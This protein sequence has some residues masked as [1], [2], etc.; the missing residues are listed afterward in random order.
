MGRDNPEKAV[1]SKV[2]SR[3][4][5]YTCKAILLNGERTAVDRGDLTVEREDGIARDTRTEV[6]GVRPATAIRRVRPVS[7]RFIRSRHES[8]Q[9]TDMMV[10]ADS[11]GGT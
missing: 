5:T 1:V 4:W 11:T 6:E 2:V 3:C 10:D 9:W 7:V 8:P